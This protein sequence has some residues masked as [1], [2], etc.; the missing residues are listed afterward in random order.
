MLKMTLQD[1]TSLP[2][3]EAVEAEEYWN[4][5]S[6]R[7]LT[8]TAQAGAASLD[9]LTAAL[10]EENLAQVTLSSDDAAAPA[11]NVYNGYVLVL[12]CGLQSVQTAAETADTQAAYEKRLVLRLGKRTYLEE[13]LARLNLR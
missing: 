10:R 13:Q 5:A 1:G 6:R 9:A 3:T 12:A 7:T 8:I 2:Y 4:G 11:V